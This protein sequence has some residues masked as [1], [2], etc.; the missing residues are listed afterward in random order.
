MAALMV[1]I[2]HAA[3]RIEG[4]A[5]LYRGFYVGEAG[6]DLFFVISGFIMMYVTPN[7]FNGW[8]GQVAFLARRFGRIYPVYWAIALPLTVALVIRPNLFRHP[9]KHEN[10]SSLLLLPSHTEPILNPAWTL[11][12]ELGFYLVASFIFY[13]GWHRRVTSIALW[14]AVVAIANLLHPGPFVNPWIN[15]ALSQYSFEFIGG[16]IL[17]EI[18]Q[19]S[20]W[21]LP[22][23]VSWLGLAGASFWGLWFGLHQGGEPNEV[24][25]RMFD[26]GI[27]AVIIVGIVLKMEMQ[28][29][30]SHAGALSWLGDR[31]FSLYLIHIPLMEIMVALS[32]LMRSLPESVSILLL[33][34]ASTIAAG[35]VEIFYRGVEKPAHRMARWLGSL[36]VAR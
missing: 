36:A 12:H 7:A 25:V 5:F 24:Q 13:F 14:L 28:G 19:R 4:G 21:L 1:V 9:A 22:Q 11:I 15:T 16:M 2:Y 35:C 20:V 23:A 17:A 34:A 32:H 18:I 8:R 6:V 30:W 3:Q 33:V 10:L 27:P 31:S 29:T 26:Y